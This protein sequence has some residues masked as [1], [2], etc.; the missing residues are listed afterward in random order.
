MVKSFFAG[1]MLKFVLLACTHSGSDG[2]SGQ[3]CSVCSSM[4][5]IL[6]QT[7]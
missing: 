2:S 7:C 3:F 6:G 5:F 4:L 1:L